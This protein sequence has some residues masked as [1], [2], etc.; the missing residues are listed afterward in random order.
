MRVYVTGP[1]CDM[2]D[3]RDLVEEGTVK[4]IGYD[5]VSITKFVHG[6]RNG[7][8]YN[9]TASNGVLSY[10]NSSMLKGVLWEGKCNT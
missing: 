4:G 6:G 10:S 1:S 8:S 9:C 3:I 5:S 2:E 7:D